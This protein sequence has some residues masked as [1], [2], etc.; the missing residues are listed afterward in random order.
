MCN[1]EIFT[2][3]DEKSWKEKRNNYIS[4]TRAKYAVKYFSDNETLKEA[5]NMALKYQKEDISLFQMYCIHNFTKEQRELYEDYLNSLEKKDSL[6]Q[7]GLKKEEEVANVGLKLVKAKF[8]GYENAKLIPNGKTMYILDE[9]SSTPD[10]FIEKE[11][12]EKILLECKTTHVLNENMQ[13]ALKSLYTIQ[14]QC[15]MLT[16]GIKKAFICMS[17]YDEKDSQLD[18]ELMDIE[19]NEELVNDII[20]SCKKLKEFL[21]NKDIKIIDY[22]NNNNEDDVKIK[23]LIEFKLT[24]Y[25]DRYEEIKKLEK[26]KEE[27]N[28]FILNM[29]K[30][31]G[32]NEKYKSNFKDYCIEITKI[33]DN[34]L[35]V[36][37][38]E[39]KIK[40]YQEKLEKI[41][42]GENVLTRKGSSYIRKISRINYED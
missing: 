34:Y 18:N 15:Q 10:Y 14:V 32:L 35:S 19:Y 20:K 6:K 27:N 37:E 13:D 21:D 17:Y 29:C 3:K 2:P 23:N 28:K 26:E 25:L 24:D 5:V 39:K 1:V 41:K 16:T 36:I 30:M 12:G 31:L 8:E 40:E 33:N 22:Y 9:I 11:D 38:C 42:N 7:F 4:S